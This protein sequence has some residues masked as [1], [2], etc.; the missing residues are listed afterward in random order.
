MCRGQRA[1]S[2]VRKK[3]DADV[4]AL[5]YGLVILG[6]VKWQIA[7]VFLA[8]V[9]FLVAPVATGNDYLIDDAGAVASSSHDS[10]HGILPSHHRSERPASLR[11]VVAVLSDHAVLLAPTSA[12]VVRS[13]GDTL[14]PHS[15]GAERAGIRGP[16]V[17]A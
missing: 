7:A 3:I 16:P 9:G 11:H 15:I 12:T 5:P 4:M 17:Q 1:R 6:P 10:A 8:A 14:L 13:S 2:C